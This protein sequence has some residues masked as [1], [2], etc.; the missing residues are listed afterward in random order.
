M[1][2]IK[3][4]KKDESLTIMTVSGLITRDEIIQAFEDFVSHEVTTNLSV[5]VKIVV[6]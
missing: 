5:R 4:M 3:R 1:A 6:T 2:T